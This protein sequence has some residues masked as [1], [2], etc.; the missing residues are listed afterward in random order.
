MQSCHWDSV[1][2]VVVVKLPLVEEEE[3]V[4]AQVVD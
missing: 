1:L 2:P 4:V 3:V